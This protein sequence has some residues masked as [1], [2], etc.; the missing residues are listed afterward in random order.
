[1]TAGGFDE[2]LVMAA[3]RLV[4]LNSPVRLSW[5]AGR[6]PGQQAP[7]RPLQAGVRSHAGVISW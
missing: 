2:R 6:M 1:M 7:H 3:Q 5:P 4:A